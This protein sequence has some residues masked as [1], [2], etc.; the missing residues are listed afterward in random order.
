MEA[1]I[2]TKG[3]GEQIVEAR[4]DVPVPELIRLFYV[5]DGLSQDQLAEKLGVS[6][7]T[8]IDWMRK[9]GI[10]TRDRRALAS[11]GTAN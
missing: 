7:G 5:Q 3:R 6:R 2:I 1:Q 8:V 9:Y 4:F 10:P 11:D